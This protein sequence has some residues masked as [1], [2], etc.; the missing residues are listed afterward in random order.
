MTGGH[1]WQEW[2]FH[3]T[4]HL[5]GNDK[6][7][8]LPQQPGLI[9]QLIMKKARCKRAPIHESTMQTTRILRAVRQTVI[10]SA[11]Y[12]IHLPIQYHQNKTQTLK[13]ENCRHNC[14]VIRVV[15][16]VY[17]NMKQ[18]FIAFIKRNTRWNSVCNIVNMLNYVWTF[19]LSCTIIT[20]R[21]Q[22]NKIVY[23]Y[24]VLYSIILL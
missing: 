13:L 17:V 19:L 11:L 6:Y 15:Y 14:I 18:S 7:S 20:Y 21:R 3:K 16:N 22:N 1:T 5:N 4:K 23:Y 12:I 24:V 2:I 10:K 8:L 9:G